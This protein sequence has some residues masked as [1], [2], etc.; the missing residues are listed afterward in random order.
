M[1]QALSFFCASVIPMPRDSEAFFE[2]H[3]IV[4]TTQ[5]EEDRVAEDTADIIPIKD[6]IEFKRFTSSESDVI[7]IKLSDS[8]SASI[9]N[10][11]HDTFSQEKIMIKKD[12]LMRK[13]I[14]SASEDDSE[15]PYQIKVNHAIFDTLEKMS[16]VDASKFEQYAIE[17]GYLMSDEIAYQQDITRNTQ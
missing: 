8:Y 12:S 9:D 14:I 1:F 7:E 16:Q 10:F 13:V 5:L 17:K 4:P 2:E 11:V 6:N 3:E 15:F